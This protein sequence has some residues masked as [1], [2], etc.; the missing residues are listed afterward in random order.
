MKKLIYLFFLAA[1][2]V[3]CSSFQKQANPLFKDLVQLYE[4]SLEKCKITQVVWNTAIYDK[5]YALST[6]SKFEDYYVSDFNI[7]ISKMEEEPTI[8][9]LNS[10]IISLTTDA[11]QKIGKIHKTKDDSYDK[12]IDLYTNVIQMSKIAVTP[13][14]NLQ[15]YTNDIKELENQ[16]S[17][18]ITELK[19][20]NPEFNN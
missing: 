16:I 1:I 19:A 13:S 14:G 6:S 11:E 7:A 18:L 9:I 10:R 12:L 5:K 8:K 4:S 15:S 3:S 2:I 17:K 20:R